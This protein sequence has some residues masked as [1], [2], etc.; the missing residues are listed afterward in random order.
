MIQITGSG[1]RIRVFIVT[2]RPV[3][4]DEFG[5]GKQA[6]ATKPQHKA[7]FAIRHVGRFGLALALSF[8][9]FRRRFVA[10]LSRFFLTA[11]AG[12]GGDRRIRVQP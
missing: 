9:G 6:L 8:R 7:I 2:G 11:G 3:D 10:G 4:L 5:P 1:S 12:A